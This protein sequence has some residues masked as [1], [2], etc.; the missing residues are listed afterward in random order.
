MEIGD[1]SWD[2]TTRVTLSINKSHLLDW[3]YY[4]QSD[5]NLYINLVWC[6]LNICSS[7]EYIQAEMHLEPNVTEHIKLMWGEVSGIT[8]P[9]TCQKW[10]MTGWIGFTQYRQSKFPCVFGWGVTLFKV[11]CISALVII[12]L[13][14]KTMCRLHIVNHQNENFLAPFHEVCLCFG[15]NVPAVATA[16]W[17]RAVAASTGPGPWARTRMR[18][19]PGVERQTSLLPSVFWFDCTRWQILLTWISNVHGGKKASY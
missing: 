5:I 2:S 7:Q 11:T 15:A 12:D 8:K 6:V 13:P 4:L 9:W 10:Q 19:G 1:G 3:Q 16:A 14:I 18:S 17:A